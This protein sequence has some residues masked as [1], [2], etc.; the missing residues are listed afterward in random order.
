MSKGILIIFKMSSKHKC[1][2]FYI[3]EKITQKYVFYVEMIY[4]DFN[5]KIKRPKTWVIYFG[6]FRLWHKFGLI[7]YANN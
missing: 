2:I 3:L 7:K 6:A 5:R 1:I 4:F